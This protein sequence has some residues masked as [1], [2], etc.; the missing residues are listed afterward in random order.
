MKNH[1][2]LN[3][4]KNGN[5]SAQQKNAARVWNVQNKLVDKYYYG[6]NSKCQPTRNKIMRAIDMNTTFEVFSKR[7]RGT[8]MWLQIDEPISAIDIFRF[9]FM[10]RR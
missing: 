2:L 5:A 1:S 3:N 9:R 6:S 4:H 10:E 8:D 7:K